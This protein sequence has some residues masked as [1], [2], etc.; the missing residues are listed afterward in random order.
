MENNRLNPQGS[1]V[2]YLDLLKAVSIIGVIVIHVSAINWYTDKLYTPE[3]I[4]HTIY[5]GIV[6]SSVPIFVMVSGA[7]F[8]KRDIPT[9]TLYKKYVPRLVVAYFVW[10]T[11]Y[12]IIAC[13]PIKNFG[14]FFTLILQGHYHLWFIP[15]ITVMYMLVPIIKKIVQDKKT[16]NYYVLLALIFSS[17]LPVILGEIALYN[18]GLGES[19]QKV[20]DK[21]Y[22][23]FLLGYTVYFILGYML[24]TTEISKKAERII[25]IF[26]IIGFI[27]TPLLTIYY[28][29]TI[30]AA[31]TFYINNFRPNVFACAIAVFVFTKNHSGYLKDGTKFSKLITKLSLYGFGVYLVHLIFLELMRYTYKIT[32]ETFGAAIGIPLMT[33]IVYAVSVLASAILNKIPYINK[34]IV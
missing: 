33:I 24:S 31:N 34:Y 1:R 20:Y 8:L 9:K 14:E 30:G 5:N 21:T 12:A 15:M 22:L 28:S 23:G 13:F 27:S 16:A 7:L 10:S 32:P 25:Y 17:V 4:I 29:R 26:G 18:K 3:W 6:Q 19:L 2:L 11:V